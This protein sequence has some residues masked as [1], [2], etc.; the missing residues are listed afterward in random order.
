MSKIGRN[1]P[2]PC[3]SGKKYKKCC[4]NKDVENVPMSQFPFIFPE[5]KE[6]RSFKKY[7][8][9]NNSLELLKIFSLLQLT[10]K[11][12]SKEFRLENIQMMICS[13]LNSISS[14]V[15]YK[16]LENLIHKEY[17]SNYR[18]DPCE[19]AFTENIMFFNGNN[20]VFPG[21]TND[22]TVLNQNLLN[23]ILLYDNDLT[24]NL[25]AKIK[26]G[27]FFI[28]YLFNEIA[29]E[30]GYT[31]NIFE[32]NDWKGKIVFPSS[33]FLEENSKYFQFKKEK[34]E[35]IYKDLNITFDI[36]REFVSPLDEIKKSTSKNNILTRKPFIEFHENF[37]LVM[38]SC[39]MMCL[40][41]FILKTVKE[42]N[43]IDKLSS[44]YRKTVLNDLHKYLY[45]KWEQIDV[46]TPLS[47]EESIWRFDHNKFAYV[48]LLTVDQKNFEKRADEKIQKVKLEFENEQIE[49]LA[50]H[51]TAPISTEL[52]SL[53]F[54]K[55]KNAKYQLAT[56]YFNVERLIT[57]W[58]LDKLSLWKYLRARGRAEEKEMIMNP[59]F[60]ILSYFKWYKR[61]FESFFPTDEESPNFISF[62][63][64]IQG[65]IIIDANKKND[66]HFILYYNNDNILGYLP[67][68]KTESHA[69]IYTSE[70][71]FNGFLRVCIEKYICPIWVSLKAPKDSYGK[72]FID[73][74][75]FWLNEFYEHLN[76]LIQELESLPVEV[77]LEFDE[78]FKNILLDDLE[79][80]DL[81]KL[82]IKYRI[83]PYTRRI[84]LKIP[85]RIY[86]ALNRSDN[87]GERVLMGCV[88]KGLSNLLE[89][90]NFKGIS[91]SEIEN[92][93]DSCM[94]LSEAKMI[95]T[96]FSDNIQT[97]SRFIPKVRFIQDADTALVLEK[98]VE[99]LEYNKPIPEKILD[100][101][102]KIKL[103]EDLIN[104]LIKQIRQ[105]LEKYDSTKL[106]E[107]LLLKHE[108]LIHEGANWSIQIPTRLK[109]F[110]KYDDVVKEF[111]DYEAKRIKTSIAIRGLIEFVVA[112][113]FFGN[114]EENDD[115]IDFLLAIMIEIINYG[116]IKDSIQYKLDNPSMGLLPS[117][118]IGIDHSFYNNIL[119][120]YRND[121][122]ND[123]IVDFKESFGKKFRNNRNAKESISKKE[124]DSTTYYDNID[125]Q[126]LKDWGISLS[127]ID[128]IMFVLSEYCLSEL[129]SYSKCFEDEF[130]NIL[131]E[132]GKLNTDKI[133]AFINHFV[134][135]T[136]GKID[137]PVDL[138]NFHEIFPWRFNRRLSYLRRPILKIKNQDNSYTFLWSMRHLDSA[139]KNLQAIFY[140]GLMKVKPIYKNI[141][142][143]LAERNNIKGK[144]FREEVYN[145][146]NS[147]TYLD[148]IPYEVK[149][150]NRK[151][152]NQDRDILI[153]DK[154]YGDIDILAFDHNSKTIYSIECKN[155][156][157][158]KIVYDFKNNIK[159]Y[160][161]KHIPKHLNREKWLRTN[162]SQI[163]KVF[164]FQSD[165]YQVK[166]LV[167][168]SYRIPVNYIEKT[169]IP[170]YSLNEIKD[171]SIFY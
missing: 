4:I 171:S 19:A 155:T 97:E 68:I 15:N 95:L 154:N 32:D 43:E 20:I 162:K 56:S 100:S 133:E 94:P 36:I 26:D 137:K 148:I 39:Q 5:L 130:K 62:D 114:K 12:Q 116:T 93:L 80:N 91:E 150:L 63:F 169:S 170:I 50:F 115:D 30:L 34:I 67:V 33:K 14:S 142:R 90:A 166:S 40:N 156:K 16:E 61:N 141:N 52:Y 53:M 153:A 163:A 77:I 59:A 28:L 45:S 120:K 138:K 98:N 75:L 124:N 72:N 41:H 2:C 47:N 8:S 7:I 143:L 126:F 140:N 57:Y 79:T 82:L 128:N 35:R 51:V 164:K 149:I 129:K 147:N 158:V 70:E 110:S 88:I 87:H 127:E 157:Q 106:L 99:W 31:R 131:R 96:M 135:K 48:R 3:G 168:S 44:L 121:I 144:E 78:S 85:I 86:N 139:S 89:I 103:C 9:R 134:L 66:R 25:K 29:E 37:Y 159:E 1:D 13:N 117:G 71:L 11:N 132:K 101:K 54:Q 38:P 152:K 145:W 112:E 69:P 125:K 113:P 46:K 136:R 74:I 17:E 81:A 42:F 146:L 161:E 109:C 64:A 65:E 167:I 151:Y 102:Q 55:I 24:E 92:I 22:S 108:S 76:P 123:E 84:H 111:R 10:P 18:E 122:T 165:E 160:I 104:S 83:E 105:R 58:S 73:S 6:S 118:R 23:T 49:F 119:V 21:M 60:S 107:F 27:A